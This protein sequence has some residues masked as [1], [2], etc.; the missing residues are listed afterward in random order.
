MNARTTTRIIMCHFLGSWCHPEVPACRHHSAHGDGRQHKHS[1]GH[2]HQVRYH[3]P[4]RGLPLHRRQRVQQEDPQ[5]E[6]RGTVTPVRE[7]ERLREEREKIET[8]TTCLS[9]SICVCLFPV[10]VF[11]WSRSVLTRFG[12]NCEFWPDPPQP[13]NTHS[14]KVNW[15]HTF[16]FWFTAD[17]MK[18]SSFRGRSSL[19]Q[20]VF[21]QTWNLS[22]QQIP[23][24]VM[25]TA[26]AQTCVS[27]FLMLYWMYILCCVCVWQELLTALWQTRG[28]WWLWLE[29]G[30]MTDQ[31]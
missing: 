24:V 8:T 22:E 4:W 13:T 9:V 27:S 28:R 19:H 25:I 1:Q 26:V 21:Y 11:R 23:G 2:S 6:R 30:P 17:K 12:P 5:R 14:S 16:I 20:L 3:P 7:R 15:K 29:T 10:C 31:L 18:L